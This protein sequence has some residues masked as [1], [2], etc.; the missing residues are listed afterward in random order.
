MPKSVKNQGKRIPGTPLKIVRKTDGQKL[1]KVTQKAPQS[2][3]HG[4]QKGTKKTPPK[5]SWSR[6][7]FWRSFGV[8][9]GGILGLFWSDF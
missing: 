5:R 8:D 6:V 4:T 9:L 2:D 7:G 1:E 3:P